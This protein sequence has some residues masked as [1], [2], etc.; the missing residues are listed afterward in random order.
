MLAPARPITDK[1]VRAWADEFGRVVS[2]HPGH[3]DGG[4]LMEAV[5]SKDGTAIGFDRL[6]S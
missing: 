4:A 5:T 2:S 3:G 6:G 1:C